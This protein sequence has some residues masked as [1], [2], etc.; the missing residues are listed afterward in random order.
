MEN[1]K[2]QIADKFIKKRSV[3]TKD[4]RVVRDDEEPQLIT[5]LLRKQL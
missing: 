2:I 3:I 5:K 1:A 4:G